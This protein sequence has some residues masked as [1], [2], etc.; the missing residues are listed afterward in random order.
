M[1]KKPFFTGRPPDSSKIPRSPQIQPTGEPVWKFGRID[2][3]GPWCPKCLSKDL[4]LQIVQRL[5]SFEQSSWKDLENGGSHFI[6]VQEIIQEA[7]N[8]LV[9]LKLDDTDQLFSLRLS[10]RERIWGLR[11]IDTFS[12]LWWDPDHQICPSF[13]KHT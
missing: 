13:K 12:I 7:K 6:D 4:L 9:K 1:S 3:D 11:F 2:F 10:N 5:K 8:R